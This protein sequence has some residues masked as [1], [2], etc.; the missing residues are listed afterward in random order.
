MRGDVTQ[1]M[2]ED[3]GHRDVAAQW[4]KHFIG[5]HD[6]GLQSLQQRI[7][8]CQAVTRVQPL[9]LGSPEYVELELFLTALGNGAPVI[10]PTISR[11]RGE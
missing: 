4:P 8:H 1:A 3:G 2:A 7:E 11:L 5:G 10:A 9:Q 6:L